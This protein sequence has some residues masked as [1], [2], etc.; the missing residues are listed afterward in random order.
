MRPGLLC[1][2]PSLCIIRWY[3][4]K[5]TDCLPVPSPLLSISGYLSIC[6]SCLGLEASP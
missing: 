5:G 4:K 1:L 6:P 3:S 2:N